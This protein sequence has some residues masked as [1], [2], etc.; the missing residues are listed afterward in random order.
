MTHI[1]VSG[2]AYSDEKW[3]RLFT[4]VSDL[5]WFP[6][7][8]SEPCSGWRFQPA[9]RRHE[10][11][12]A[13]RSLKSA[14]SLLLLP[15]PGTQATVTEQQLPAFTKI[16]KMPR[17][18]RSNADIKNR[19]SSNSAVTIIVTSGEKGGHRNYDV[20]LYSY[21]AFQDMRSDR[22]LVWSEL[23][24]FSFLLS[25]IEHR[26]LRLCITGNKKEYLNLM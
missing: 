18:Q 22:G 6:V 12:S 11:D 7:L 19:H 4:Q 24:L 13:W 21:D 1:S 25:K 20:F 16:I 26:N 23:L 14:A 5:W 2:F 15:H 10:R 3:K 17:S 9:G 8:S